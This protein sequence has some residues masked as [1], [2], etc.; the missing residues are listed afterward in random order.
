M[1]GK[2]ESFRKLYP[3]L[4]MESTAFDRINA[5]LDAPA[6]PEDGAIRVRDL[7][8]TKLQELYVQV[9]QAIDAETERLKVLTTQCDA[10]VYLFTERMEEDDI[11]SIKFTNGVTIGSSVEPY[12]NVTDRSILNSWI[13]ETGQEELLTLN[14]QTLAS[15]IKQAILEGKDLPPGVDVYMKTKLTARGLKDQPKGE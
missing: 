3:K 13:K 2:Y 11:T 6:Y 7:D 10:L 12:P 4:P 14:Y 5:V 8:N 1:A 15:L 9:R